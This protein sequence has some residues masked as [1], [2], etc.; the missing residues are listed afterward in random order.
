MK[1]IEHIS[2]KGFQS[3]FNTELSLAPGVNILIGPSYSGKSAVLRA[4]RW[5][6][7]NEPKG[8]SFVND[9]FSKKGEACKVT[10]MF[11]DGTMVERKKGTGVNRYRLLQDGKEVHK[12]DNFGTGV[13]REI[14]QAIEMDESYTWNELDIDLNFGGQFESAF[15][16]SET[17]R[18]PALVFGRLIGLDLIDNATK[19]T[20]KQKRE[21]TGICTSAQVEIDEL[22]YKLSKFPD[23]ARADALLEEASRKHLDIYMPLVS[24]GK[25]LVKLY[26]DYNEGMQRI[27]VLQPAVQKGVELLGKLITTGED[28]Q[29]LDERWKALQAL[30]TNYS[31]AQKRLGI[32]R[33]AVEKGGVLLAKLIET[34]NELVGAEIRVGNL[35]LKYNEYDFIQGRIKFMNAV[36][37]HPGLQKLALA[38]ELVEKL[39]AISPRIDRLRDLGVAIEGAVEDQERA[40]FNFNENLVSLHF[41]KQE[42]EVVLSKT[43]TCPLSGGEFF[44]EC[45]DT[46]KQEE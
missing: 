46:I 42:L 11:D 4:I 26:T 16:L 27:I 23:I 2:I 33:P 3:H 14:L 22:K 18:V 9:S 44:Q 29:T 6:F 10:I 43:E 7:R 41:A 32:L 24:K 37:E 40:R 28:F 20:G 21:Q 36:L 38:P 19:L 13:P 17:P 35:Q 45:K 34:S 31:E 25:T 12:F 15:L 5:V 1:K 30:Y 39:A 8:D